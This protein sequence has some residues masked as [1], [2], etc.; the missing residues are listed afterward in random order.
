[1]TTARGS[2]SKGR[3]RRQEIID[4]ALEL[5]ARKGYDR[6]SVREIA[7]LT[8]LSQAGLLHHFE[9]KEELFIEVLRQRDRRNESQY[10]IEESRRVSIEGLTQIVDHNAAEPGLVRLYVAMSAESTD[11]DSPARRFFIDR[12]ESLRRDLA[13][14]IRGRQN[15]GE[16]DPSLDPDG[17]AT[18]LLAAADGLQIQWLLT[19]DSVDMG[20]RLADLVKLLS[21]QR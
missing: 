19:P 5:F 21:S 11:A 8:G 10:D 1:M 3:A 17:V 4:V 16:L 7:R 13:A 15:V 14:D 6:T 9:T 2:Y 12:Y 18:V 20:D